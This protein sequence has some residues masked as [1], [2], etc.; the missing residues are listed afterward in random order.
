[1]K[2][3]G[4]LTHTHRHTHTNAHAHADAHAHTHLDASVLTH[5]NMFTRYSL[6]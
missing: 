3:F 1:M 5:S 2:Q 4:G 6:L